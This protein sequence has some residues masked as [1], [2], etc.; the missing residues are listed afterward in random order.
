MRCACC[1]QN[2]GKNASEPR[3][4]LSQVSRRQQ[5]QVAPSTLVQTEANTSSRSEVRHSDLVALSWRLLT[6]PRR[7]KSIR[8]AIISVST[9]QHSVPAFRISIIDGSGARSAGQMQ[10]GKKPQWLMLCRA[11]PYFPRVLQVCHVFRYSNDW[12][13]Q[14]NGKYINI[15]YVSQAGARGLRGEYSVG[16]QYEFWG[17][18]AD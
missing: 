17:V 14:S 3:T 11:Q 2:I 16:H 12:S 15:G 13:T 4:V 8:R 10:K 7:T 5:D 6:A 1:T 18:T 9:I